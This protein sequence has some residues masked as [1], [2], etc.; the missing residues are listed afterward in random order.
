MLGMTFSLFQTYFQLGWQHICS[1][2]AADHLAFLLA[3]SAPYALA[4]WRRRL[5]LVTSFT[6]GH[7]LTLALAVL[8]GPLPPSAWVE[9]LIP[10]TVI[11]TALLNLRRA[12]GPPAG[13]LVFAGAN[14]LAAGF[15]LVHGLGFA[16]YL[17]AL[18]GAGR[19]PVAE[20][21]AFNLGVEAGQVLVVSVLLFSSAL[22]TRRRRAARAGWTLVASGAAVGMA[23]LLLGQLLAG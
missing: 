23:G 6:V 18:L 15:G 4:D 9:L 21:L 11:I 2:Y 17:R 14:A 5:A 22:L 1:P 19:R 10:I 16:G 8:G 20:L 12:G 13:P 3:L 7:S